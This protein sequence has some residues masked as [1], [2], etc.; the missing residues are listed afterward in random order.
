MNSFYSEEEL[1][2]LDL[3]QCGKNVLISKKCSIYSPEQIIIGDNVRIDDFCIL[4]GCIQLGSNIHISAFCALYGSK[5]IIIKDYAGMSPR[6]IIFSAVDD[7]SG[8]FLIGPV[9]SAK[10]TNVTG[11]TVVL[12]KY[13]QLGAN[14]IVM[15]NIKISEGAVTGAM[16]FVNKDLDSWSIFVGVPAKFLKPRGKG[17][18]FRGN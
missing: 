1:K 5:G 11:G 6:S 7:F 15:P 18:L 12:E 16:T 2:M 10:L 9:N 8:E 17:L 3:K 4:S 13:T 14:T